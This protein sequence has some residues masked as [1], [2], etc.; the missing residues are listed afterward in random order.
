ML[1]DGKFLTLVFIF[2]EID[3]C[4]Q[5]IIFNSIYLYIFYFFFFFIYQI[6]LI[7]CDLCINVF[8][9]L[10]RIEILS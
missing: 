3:W 5:V 7:L 10:S 2:E 4:Y 9:I 8:I 1:K 6:F